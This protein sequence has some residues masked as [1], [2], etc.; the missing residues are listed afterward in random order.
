MALAETYTVLPPRSYS[1]AACIYVLLEQELPPPHYLSV[2]GNTLAPGKLDPR[3]KQPNDPE[4]SPLVD[5]Y[6]Y[7]TA[8]PYSWKLN[9][10]KCFTNRVDL[11]LKHYSKKSLERLV[12]KKWFITGLYIL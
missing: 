4:P 5:F 9:V 3:E 1:K 7:F 2:T 12:K 6:F 11:A 8:A 10:S